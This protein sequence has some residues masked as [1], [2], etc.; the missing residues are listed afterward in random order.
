MSHRSRIPELE[1][2]EWKGSKS[3]ADY[4]R[5]GRDLARDFAWELH[6]S[7][8]ELQAILSA[9][10]GHPLLLGLDVKIRARRVAAHLRRAAEG[11]VGVAAALVK[12]NAE[13]KRQFVAP[14]AAAKAKTKTKR[15]WEL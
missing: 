5:T 1:S 2:I 11:Q 6:S 10:K 7:A 4:S 13:Y 12:L 15:P 8:D 3:V 14:A 9:Q